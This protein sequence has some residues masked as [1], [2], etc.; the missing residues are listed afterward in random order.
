MNRAK[1]WFEQATSDLKHARHSLRDGDYDWACFA[2]Q[3]AAEKVVKAL[4]MKR[5]SIAWGHSVFELLENVPEDVRPDKELIEL[6]KTL[7]KYYIPTRYPNAHP[8]GA[9]YKYYTQEE[10]E[11][12]IKICEEVMNFCVSKGV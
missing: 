11:K 7:D 12:A 4:Y 3:Q 2:A 10:A 5:N 6:T 1:D 9:A 8:S